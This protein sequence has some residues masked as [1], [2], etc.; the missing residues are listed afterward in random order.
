MAQSNDQIE[1]KRLIRVSPFV[2]SEFTRGEFVYIPNEPSAELK[3]GMVV[4]HVGVWSVVFSNNVFGQPWEQIPLDSFSGKL[5]SVVILN[6]L[7]D[8]QRRGPDVNPAPW[9]SIKDKILEILDSSKGYRLKESDLV[10]ALK[11]QDGLDA[12]LVEDAVRMC[13]A[14]GAIKAH[15]NKEDDWIQLSDIFKNGANRR[16]F[17]SGFSEELL[18]KSRRVDF[19]I[20]HKGTVGSY[21]EGLLRTFLR[22]LIPR[23]YELSTGFV[24]NSPRQ[25][26]IIIWDSQRY[27]ALF[28]DGDTVVVPEAA[29]RAIIEVK[30]TLSP[31]SLPEALDL[32]DDVMR[33]FPPR[34]PI[35]KGIFGFESG[36][37]TSESIADRVKAFHAGVRED[38][39][40]TREHSYICQ[41]VQTICVPNAHLLRQIYVPVEQ[42]DKYP[43]PS[44]VWFNSV[45]FGDMNTAAFIAD[46]LSYLD[47]TPNAKVAQLELFRPLQVSEE[48]VGGV[49]LFE[50]DWI[51]RTYRADQE[52]LGTI[53]GVNRYI[54]KYSQFR[55]GLISAD[56]LVADTDVTVDVRSLP[57]T[58]GE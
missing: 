46:I 42:P 34:H 28:R 50:E 19:L 32:L 24:E 35:F 12:D 23:Q 45:A 44:L 47:V 58:T 1:V 53:D 41:G 56:E 52:W 13:I 9:L 43:R 10:G 15:T 33:S 26:D 25:L 39:V 49:F 51:P 7:G 22:T 37:E 38:G 31:A 17:L 36:Y 4:E 3:C 21:R 16:K 48:V 54:H 2:P 29:V 14:M 20:G 11:V 27:A 57:M 30:T 40:I 5:A 55:A 6:H 18:L 8:G